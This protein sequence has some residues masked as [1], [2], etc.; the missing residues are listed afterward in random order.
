MK[1][2]DRTDTHVKC[3]DLLPGRVKKTSILCMG[4][5]TVIADFWRVINKPTLRKPL[6]KKEG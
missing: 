5:N 1:N 2:I 4:M 3:R 6:A